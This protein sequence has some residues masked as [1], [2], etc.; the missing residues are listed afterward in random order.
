MPSAASC[1]APVGPS[2]SSCPS[3]GCSKSF[4]L[5]PVRFEE[6]EGGS[7]TCYQA[8]FERCKQMRQ[9]KRC[10]RQPAQH[11]AG[12]SHH[13]APTSPH[14]PVEASAGGL[15][16]SHAEAAACPA[17]LAPCDNQESH[18]KGLQLAGVSCSGGSSR[19]HTSLWDVPV[20]WKLGLVVGAHK[21]QGH[22]SGEQR[23]AVC[24]GCSQTQLGSHGFLLNINHFLW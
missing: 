11:P 23:K 5:S 7:L 4:Q 18:P 14:R 13:R 9:R 2:P 16:C 17:E 1:L 10:A 3:F 20:H 21:E 8:V 12:C 6:G 22:G 15:N 19:C 24:T